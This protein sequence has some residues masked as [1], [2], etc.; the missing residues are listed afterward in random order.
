MLSNGVDPYEPVSILKKDSYS[1]GFLRAIDHALM[2]H[3]SD[4]PQDILVW[5]D[6]LSGKIET[7]PIAEELYKQPGRAS[8]EDATVVMTEPPSGS[9]RHRV[10]SHPR[11]APLTAPP[12]TLVPSP[13]IETSGSVRRWNAKV[14]GAVIV[15]LLLVGGGAIFVYWKQGGPT[16]TQQAE[17]SIETD[18]QQ[19]LASLLQNAEIAY[20]AGKLLDKDGGAIYLYQQILNIDPANDKAASRIQEIIELNSDGIRSDL[21]EGFVEKAQSKFQLLQDAAPDSKVV[22][23]LQKDVEHATA[24]QN[25]ISKLLKQADADFKAGRLIAPKSR[26]ALSTYRHIL[27]LAPDNL[28][29][30]RGVDNVLAHY[31]GLAKKNLAEGKVADVESNI[32]NILFINPDSGAAK[33][34]RNELEA[35]KVRNKHQREINRLL[36]QARRALNAGDL[37]KP[38]N[39]NALY[40]Y[41]RVLKMDKR[42]AT[43]KQGIENVK[44]KL[45]SLFENYLTAGDFS[46]AESV[47]KSVENVMPKSTLAH[48]IRAEWEQNK[49]GSRP[50]IEIITEMIGKFKQAF[51]S[52]NS[53]ALRGLSEYQ[54]NR[55]A[56]LQQLFSNYRSFKIDISDGKFIGRERK[57]TADIA[58][59]D[60]VNIQGASVEPGSWSRFQIVIQK[61][62]KGQWRVF[63]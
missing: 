36:S 7:P 15:I 8:D 55:Q 47:I 63:W 59:V 27:K 51:E 25:E 61:N 24:K 5:A 9:G 6:M 53:N 12:A 35:L 23:A 48:E 20:K 13:E 29:A 41:Q 21:A 1:P 57:G 16:D 60:L 44:K 22:L 11:T 2:F 26:N 45:K 46:S 33:E 62:A 50:D 38:A 54:T 14:L 40:L 43:A 19:K 4:R 42:N 31:V 30:K 58:I 28:D 3:A 17:Q 56:F 32:D 10:A 52:R 18:K 37:T 34:L 39:K 49:P